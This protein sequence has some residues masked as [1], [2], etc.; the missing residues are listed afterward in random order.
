M[1]I[2]NMLREERLYSVIDHIYNMSCHLQVDSMAMAAE[3]LVKIKYYFLPEAKFQS[4][5]MQ[6][7]K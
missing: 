5:Y 2:F 7:S 3:A 1:L 6:Q 4:W